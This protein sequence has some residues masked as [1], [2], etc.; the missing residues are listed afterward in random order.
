MDGAIKNFV[1]AIG[2]ALTGDFTGA[3]EKLKEAGTQVF[4][5]MREGA[6]GSFASIVRDAGLAWVAIRVGGVAAAAAVR[7]A[8][9]ALSGASLFGGIAAGA[10]GLLSGALALLL[11]WP[12]L[13]VAAFVAA[14]AGIVFFWDD[15][16]KGADA[17]WEGLKSGVGFIGDGFAALW[18]ELGIGSAEASETAKGELSEIGNGGAV[19]ALATAFNAAFAEMK[20]ASTETAQFIVTAFAGIMPQ[21]GGLVEALVLQAEAALLRLET[22]IQALQAAVTAAAEIAAA[23][24]G[25]VDAIAAFTALET[26]AMAVFDRLRASATQA[27]SDIAAA[28][29]QFAVDWTLTTAGADEAWATIRATAEETAQ[30]V[31]EAFANIVVDWSVLAVGAAEAAAA[32]QEPFLGLVQQIQS[33]FQQIS[34]SVKEAMDKAVEL[35]QAAADKMGQA[36]E[37]LE[38]RIKSLAKQAADLA[39]AGSGSGG[40]GGTTG[41]ATGGRVIGPGSGTSNSILARLSN[42]EFVIRAAAVRKYGARFFEHAQPDAG[43]QE[44][45]AGVCD[46]RR[47][48]DARL[49][50]AR[51]SWLRA[52]RPGAARTALDRPARLGRGGE[53]GPVIGHAAHPRARRRDVCRSDCAR[54]NRQ[55]PDALRD[56][57]TDPIR[58]SQARLVLRAPMAVPLSK[59]YSAMRAARGRRGGESGEDGATHGRESRLRWTASNSFF[60]PPRF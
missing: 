53:L 54:G 20:A 8:F 58:R 37:K 42:G 26:A 10:G 60:P 40:S 44:Q 14:A 49:P 36:L 51:P 7:I 17:V 38:A 55:E 59:A 5:S 2:S 39:K 31:Q 29:S 50:N 16:K 28:F 33:V 45:A 18:R 11:S 24:A 12:A 30:R 3:W 22:R 27:A 6:T 23:S 25:G 13:L 41:F 19:D 43:R 56:L 21:V 4:N 34:A 52:G 48:E 57:A 46:R 47:G 15:I 35:V 9:T 1:S 32:V